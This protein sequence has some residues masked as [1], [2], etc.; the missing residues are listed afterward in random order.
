MF[1]CFQKKRLKWGKKGLIG[2]DGN[3]P[4]DFTLPCGGVKVMLKMSN[5]I[6]FIPKNK[7]QD[8]FEQKVDL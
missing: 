3:K 7:I 1:V 5:L 2:I 4:T 8:I 6:Y